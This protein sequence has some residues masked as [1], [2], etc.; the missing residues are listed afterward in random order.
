MSFFFNTYYFVRTPDRESVPRDC[1]AGDYDP[2]DIS[3]MEDHSRYWPERYSGHIPVKLKVRT[4]LFITDPM[5]KR[6]APNKIDHM[7]Y[8]CLKTIPV[9]SLK[10][11]LRSAYETITNSRYGVFSKTQHRKRLGF[12]YEAKA[13]LIPARIVKND[14]G[15]L[16]IELFRGNQPNDRTLFAAW[17]PLYSGQD[18]KSCCN[19][20]PQDVEVENVPLRLYHY[21][22]EKYGKITEFDVWVVTA[23]P[24]VSQNMQIIS[25]NLTPTENIM[26]ARGFFTVSGRTIWNKHD[27]RF[28]FRGNGVPQERYPLQESVRRKYEALVADYQ[29]THEGNALPPDKGRIHGPHITDSSRATLREGDCVYARMGGAS[30]LGIYPVQISRELHEKAPW[31]FLPETLRPA[32]SLDKLS[33]ADRLFGWVNQEG[34]G[35]WRGKVRITTLR[36]EGDGT[37]P[38]LGFK[39]PLPLAILGSPKPAQTRFYLGDA[40]GE[41]QKKGGDKLSVGYSGNKRLRGRKAYL[42]HKIVS[43]KK[44]E[45]YWADPYNDRTSESVGGMYQEYRQLPGDGERNNQNR[46]ITG[47][48]PR[49]TVFTF[50]VV[51]ENLTREELGALLTL[52]SL[53]EQNHCF[54]LGF[55]KPLGLGSVT[56]SLNLKTDVILPVFRGEEL[57]QRYLSL[58]LGCSGGISEIERR[59]LVQEYKIAVARAYGSGEEIPPAK[60]DSWKNLSWM[61][62]FENDEQLELGKIWADAMAIDLKEFPGEKFSLFALLEPDQRDELQSAYRE[63]R[64]FFEEAMKKDGGWGKLPFVEDLLKSMQ[65]PDG[66]VH[67]P[68]TSLGRSDKGYEWFVQ[69]ESKQGP[70]VSLPEM[71]QPLNH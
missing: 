39:E 59:K 15:E 22:K 25:R 62:I 27:E 60:Y 5:S 47:W 20:V 18:E 28:F 23:I 58:N 70:K 31:E 50:D 40:Q 44:Q 69:N 63:E 11:M 34:S 57:R 9:T 52:L 64:M 32:E 55:G 21:R 3:K 35:A 2:S 61:E 30:V 48:M 54:R 6:P 1:F 24:G 49:D 46:S 12:R 29:K 36:F 33:P 68:R 66:P 56:L 38:V 45:D 14:N 7:I 51:V 17:V 4:P 37:S 42:H 26:L 16:E 19:G 67:T 10:G 41:P 13:D 65:G 8:D 43:G 53:S 71:C